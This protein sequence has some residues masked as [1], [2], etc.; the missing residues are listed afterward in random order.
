MPSP[1][2]PTP[3]TIPPLQP[4]HKQTLILLHG[5]GSNAPLFSHQLLTTPFPIPTTTSTLTGTTHSGPIA[6]LRTAFPHAKFVFPTASRRPTAQFN[7]SLINQWF[8]CWTP[9]EIPIQREEL[10]IEGLRESV[11]FIH[12]VVRGEV[13]G[14]EGGA[15]RVIVGGL[16]QGCAAGLVAGLLWEGEGEEALGGLVGFCGRLPFGRGVGGVLGDGGKGDGIDGEGEGEGGNPFAAVGDD[17]EGARGEVVD[18]ISP[19]VRAVNYLREVLGIPSSAPGASTDSLI[20]Q[21]TPVFLGHGT[22]DDKVPICLGQEA[23]R[24]FK[25]MGMDV[26]WHEYQG[27]GHWYSERMLGDFVKFVR[28]KVDWEM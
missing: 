10:Q 2:Y 20:F 6:T 4:P 25:E 14:V 28:E 24:C 9:Y 8:D 16:S 7:R 11:G 21:K 26:T 15:G 3:L 13:E 23:A 12:E 17:G 18:G 19:P 22:A 5:R 27:L 1:D